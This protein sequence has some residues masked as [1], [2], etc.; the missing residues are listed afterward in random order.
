MPKSKATKSRI[1]PDLTEERP[2][3]PKI[4]RLV[5]E[6][7]DRLIVILNDPVFIKAWN[8][9]EA[10]KPS[11]FP[12][13]SEMFEGQFGDNRAAHVLHRIQGWE[14]HKA[15]LIK[16]TLELIPAKKA[17]PEEYPEAGKL[18][19]E[20]ARTMPAKSLTQNAR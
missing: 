18:E 15:A 20:I 11:A 9:A 4:T 3:F 2:S 19:S 5:M 8:N 10:Q 6:E 16:Q 17:N 12:L 13:G 14:L 1:A 7:R